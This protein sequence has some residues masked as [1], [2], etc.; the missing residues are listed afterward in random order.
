[1]GELWKWVE[2]ASKQAQCND[3]VY[4]RERIWNWVVEQDAIGRSMVK[5]GQVKVRARV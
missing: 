1:V 2:V 4:A 5:K 3:V